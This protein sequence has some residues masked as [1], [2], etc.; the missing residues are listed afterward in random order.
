MCFALFDT[1]ILQNLYQ[2]AFTFSNTEGKFLIYT[3]SPRRAV[4]CCGHTLL[5]N[6][7]FGATFAVE[8]DEDNGIDPEVLFIPESSADSIKYTEEV[9]MI[10]EF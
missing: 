3:L 2:Y 9:I 10:I 8:E 6:G 4:P 1:L 5:C 7:Q